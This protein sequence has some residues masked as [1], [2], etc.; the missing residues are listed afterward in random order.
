MKRSRALFQSELGEFSDPTAQPNQPVVL[1]SKLELG[2]GDLTLDAWGNQKVSQD[3]SM[4]HGMWT[5]DIPSG[6][7]LE[8]KNTTEVPLET[9]ASSVDGM[10]TITS[11]SVDRF[12]IE[13]R[14]HARYQP[15][16]GWHYSASIL[17]PLTATGERRFGAFSEQ[18]GFYFEHRGGESLY[19]CR[20][21]TTTSGGIVT[22]AACEL[23][24]IPFAIDFTKGNIYDIQA[25]WRGVGNVK[26][27]IG[28]AATGDLTLVHTMSLLNTLTGLSVANPAL[29]IAFECEQTVDPITLQCGCVDITSEG[30]FK[31]NRQLNLVTS[32]DIV[33]FTSTETNIVAIRITTTLSTGL[34]NT[35]D[36]ALR[37]LL[38]F[39]SVDAL[40][41][42]YLTRDASLFAGS[43]WT[44]LG[45]GLNFI[46]F[47]VSTD[48]VF[49]PLTAGIPK[50]EY[51]RVQSN[52]TE[53]I[54]NPD[55][56]YGDFFM[57]AGDYLVL[58]LKGKTGN[59]EGG[60]T[61][62]WGEEI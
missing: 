16:R 32:E 30:G 18:N 2:S 28:N 55:E 23:I 43:T 20:R 56:Q 60:A 12:R 34:L 9:N 44:K 50:L 33:S 22:T 62:E 21:T 57:T 26:F 1:P 7:W 31:E 42:A 47:A 29:P 8:C 59:G 39:S 25:Q 4:F 45:D 52:T 5:Y 38:Y 3:F 17:L 10:L 14:R 61:I 36:I 27:F 48:I 35:R 51:R 37:R 24:T 13:S 54:S 53:E 6:L 15:N 11:D 49:D 19:A 41:A 58:T 40:C 46:D